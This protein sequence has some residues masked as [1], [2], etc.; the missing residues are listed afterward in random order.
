MIYRSRGYLPHLEMQG[1]TYFLTFRLS[2]TL[3][4]H[5]LEM[6]RQERKSLQNAADNQNR[7]LS[8]PEEQR[9]K[10]LESRKVQEYLDHGYGECW[11]KE[12]RIAQ[13]VVEAIKHFEGERYTSHAWCIMPNHVHWI[14]SPK[15]TREM[16]KLDSDLIRIIQ[17]LKSF[18]SHQANKELKRK[19]AFWEREYYDHLVRSSEE[20]ARLVSYTVENPVKAGLCKKWQDCK[21]TGCSGIISN[22]L[23]D[24]LS[25]QSEL[26]GGA[27]GATNC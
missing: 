6:I 2:G 25:Q 11:L 5:V 18:T 21:W 16:G 26:A 10:Y 23:R 17:A 14:L 7:G 1:A 9:L 20:F 4:Q 22:L 8:T 19:G 13:M 27:A 3:P 12:E 24:S 15:R